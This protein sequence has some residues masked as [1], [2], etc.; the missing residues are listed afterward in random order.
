M[1]ELLVDGLPVQFIRAH[2]FDHELA[3][4]K[5][6]D[7]CYGFSFKVSEQAIADAKIVEA[8]I[9]NT[10][11]PVAEA[12]DLESEQREPS[13]RPKAGHVRWLGGLRFFAWLDRG[14]E[15][16]A[17]INV[18]VDGEL[19]DQAHASRWHHV[20][21]AADDEKIAPAFD[22]HLPDRFADGRVRLARFVNEMGE[23]L[24]G[25]PVT[26]VAFQD[27]LE[28]TVSNFGEIESEKLRAE[29]F[30]RLVP[31]SWPLS[32]FSRWQD[33]FPPP[34]PPASDISA[35]I[36][37]VG[38]G[39]LEASIESLRAQSHNNWI[40][41]DLPV[42]EEGDFDPAELSEFLAGEGSECEIVVFA[43]AGTEFAP[44]AIGRLLDAYANHPDASAVYGDFA[45]KGLE[46]RSWPIALP[47]FDYERA[48]EQGYCAFV[49]AARRKGL[50][51]AAGEA[52]DIFGLFYA[53]TERPEVAARSV[54][55][56]PGVL[57]TL[58]NFDRVS[59]AESLALAV[60]AHLSQR[61]IEADVTPAEGS[62]FPAVHIARA[63]G[64]PSV[65][66]IIPT[67]NR[68]DLLRRCLDSISSAAAQHSAEV[69]VVDNDSSDPETLKFLT[70]LARGRAKVLRVPGHFNFSK[71]NNV[72]V[73][74][75]EGEYLVLL[76][77]DVEALDDVWLEEMLGRAVEPDVGAVGA[78]LLW[79]SGVVQHGGVVLGWGYA[80]N[81]AFEDRMEGDPGYGD[82]L[83]AAHECSAVTAACLLTKRAD[84]IAAGGMDVINFPI[85][86]N[87]I[88][89]C[90]KL[91][92][93]G[94]RVVFTPHARLR[95]LTSASRGSNRASD[96]LPL[97]HREASA[98]RARWLD[99]LMADPYYNPILSLDTIPFSALAWP[100]R[101][102]APRRQNPPIPGDVPPG[103]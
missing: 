25:S 29:L 79:P 45:I 44:T 97:F 56:V 69:I 27:G 39:D 89:Y 64:N 51:R 1:V 57:A 15:D 73:R 5:I 96:R 91:R 47:A 31:M 18:L 74:S 100:P 38:D 70:S 60:A 20:G 68:V 23:E 75:A 81:H 52:A 10:Q 88:D 33:R 37:L 42:Q 12:I 41:F 62:V 7:G 87:D 26:F 67:R 55:H 46:G 53:L 98:L 50:E 86:F 54:V 78:M 22:F 63:T 59:A 32:E 24:P 83:L 9:A 35:G 8:R 28:R 93:A 77:N 84:Y 103:I 14:P 19:I 102:M 16:A 13:T 2:E 90:L 101:A 34:E 71:L 94:K 17:F 21:T 65:S 4:E 6:G 95:H 3:A 58:P 61:G 80:A 66:I 43:L 99:T 30:D 11:F 36:V 40:A 92:A 72:A 82:L 48:L 85:N 49:Y 76:N